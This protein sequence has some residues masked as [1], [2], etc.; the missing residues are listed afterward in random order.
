MTDHLSE[1]LAASEEM[2]GLI[3]GE[4]QPDPALL[5]KQ[6]VDDHVNHYT[7]G[8]VSYRK[9]VTETDDFAATEW[10]GEG[11]IVRDAGGREIGKL[12]RAERKSDDENHGR[13]RD[14]RQPP[15]CRALP[16]TAPALA[17]RGDCSSRTII[18]TAAFTTRLNSGG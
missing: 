1:A 11:S 10:T 3:T 15:H 9:S 5:A 7:P 14:R 4:V 16:S 8:L 12:R 18:T 2:M 13:D 17:K 6:A